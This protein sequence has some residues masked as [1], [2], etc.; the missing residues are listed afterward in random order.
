VGDFPS[1]KKLNQLVSLLFCHT[2]YIVNLIVTLISLKGFECW[3]A[4]V[5]KFAIKY[6]F[7]ILISIDDL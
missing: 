3:S 1:V 4:H 5:L 6:E 2:L 7:L